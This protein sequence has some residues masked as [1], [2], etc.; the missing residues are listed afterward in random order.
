MP[1]IWLCCIHL[2]T[3]RGQ[4]VNTLLAYLKT[5]RLN[6]SHAETVT[7]AFHLHNREAKRELKLYTNGE[8]L[9]FFPVPTY[10][11]VKLDRS[12]TFRPHFET[13]RKKSSSPRHPSDATCGLAMGRWRQNTAYSCLILGLRCS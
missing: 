4:D 5:L 8:L 10:L 7:A 1:V 9:P 11:G 13:L 12:L 3:G 6:L 2:G